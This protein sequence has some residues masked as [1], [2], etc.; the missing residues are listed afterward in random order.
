MTSMESK[1]QVFVTVLV[2]L[3]GICKKLAGSSAVPNE[4]RTRASELAQEFDTLL[5]YRGKGTPA[6]HVQG[7]ELLFKITRFLPNVLHGQE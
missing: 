3:A 5:A 2:D 4:L 1:D 7:E 6:Q